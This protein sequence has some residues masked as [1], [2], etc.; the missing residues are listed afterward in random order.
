M[1]ISLLDRES[2]WRLFMKPQDIS[3][4]KPNEYLADFLLFVET[5]DE[6]SFFYSFE[7]YK[8]PALNCH[9]MCFDVCRTAYDI[10]NKI[11]LDGSFYPISEEFELLIAED[12]FIKSH[13]AD[14]NILLFHKGKNTDYY[15][16]TKQD[17]KA[18]IR[19][20]KGIAEYLINKCEVRFLY[21]DYLCYTIIDNIFTGQRSYE[22][23]ELIYR[24]TRM[25][26]TELVNSG[27][28][29]EFIQKSIHNFFYNPENEIICDRETLIDFFNLF[30]SEQFSFTFKFIINHQMSRVFERLN[31][32][33]VVDLSTDELKLFNSQKKNAKCVIIE[34][35]D[36]DEFSAYRTALNVIQTVLSFHNL[37]QHNSKLYVSFSAIVEKKSED[38]IASRFV[39]KNNI[40]LMKKRGNT[41]YLHALYNDILLLNRD[42]LP[43]AF[44]KA[45]SLHNV[46]IECKDISNQLLNLWTIVEVLIT[47]KR[48]NE[49]RI[50]T[51]C[52]ILGSVLNRNYLYSQIEQLLRDIKQCS[53]LEQSTVFDCFQET[54]IDE[55]EKLT[56]ILA[57]EK[58]SNEKEQLITLL[59]GF[60]LLQH[61]IDKFSNNV[62]KDSQSIYVYLH[63][64]TKKIHWHIMRI[65]RNRNMIVH[66][67]SYMPYRDSLVENLHFY[68]DSLLDTLI[69]YYCIGYSDNDSIYR[70]VICNETLH[71]QKLGVPIKRSKDKFN[72]R[73]LS[74]DNAL[75]LIYN[76]FNGNYVKK[77]IDA[78]IKDSATQISSDL[79]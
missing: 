28:S 67:G 18:K 53:E 56:L 66:N 49:D 74:E 32:F 40:N 6:A 11:L 55:V 27:Y 61:R 13:I 14:N 9:Y 44:Y 5:M 35:E 76:G 42:N 52:N 4:W 50:N 68:V 70:D 33:K 59:E 26:V 64:H 45:I 58:Y 65:Y 20:Y 39:I 48:D 78:I 73:M 24:L 31:N 17:I 22:T 30:S 47:S 8:H 77:A 54:D 3:H 15:D 10:E 46:A 71:H 79:I 51:I 38:M 63:Q 34:V 37:N 1:G 75:D 29:Q 69:Q 43:E 36:I 2:R 21:Y 19:E 12:P 60:P 41:S 16:L 72:N 7:S 62:F 23:K 25:F 57:L